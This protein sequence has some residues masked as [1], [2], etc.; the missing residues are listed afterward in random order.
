MIKLCNIDQRNAG[1]NVL[2]NTLLHLL[3]CLY[4]YMKNK[5]Q[6]T[7]CTIGLPY[8]EHM[9]FETCR[10]CQ[11]SNKGINLKTLH[12]FDLWCI[13]IFKDC[14]CFSSVIADKFSVRKYFELFSI[15]SLKIVLSQ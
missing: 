7:A 1:G 10:R 2:S 4:R 6:K 5:P 11:K 13:I 9:R 15:H 3:D 12:F 14:L 8:N